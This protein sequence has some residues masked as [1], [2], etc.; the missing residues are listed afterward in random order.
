MFHVSM[1]RL[2]AAVAVIFLFTV[3]A[4]R[5]AE[6]VWTTD[7]E[8]ALKQAKAENKRVLLD[9][10]GSDWC[11][12]CMK[13]KEEVFDTTAFG[14]YA[15]DKLI[16]VELDY[17]RSKAQTDAVKKQNAELAKKFKIRGYPT[18]LIVDGDG[19]V[20]GQT[21]YKPGGPYSY[22]QDLDKMK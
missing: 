12:W 11:G 14:N 5:S 17:P 6:A 1:G 4:G 22:I 15:K 9:F 10:T 20:L 21:G 3:A 13:L 7:Y 16:L 18:I 2:M 8:A 19:K